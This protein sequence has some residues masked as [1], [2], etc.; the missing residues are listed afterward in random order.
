MYMLGEGDKQDSMH[1]HLRS[2]S[3]LTGAILDSST[4]TGSQQ[5]LGTQALAQVLKGAR[6]SS[7]WRDNRKLLFFFPCRN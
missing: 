2:G 1:T 6:L 3:I 4:S 5:S 7:A